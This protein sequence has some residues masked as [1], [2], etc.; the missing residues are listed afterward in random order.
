MLLFNRPLSQIDFDA[1]ERQLG[2]FT[3]KYSY[4]SIN[5][6]ALTMDARRIRAAAR[7]GE[8]KHLEYDATAKAAIDTASSWFGA[9]KARTDF[10]VNGNADGQTGYSKNDIVVAVIDTGIDT[11]HV[12]LDGGKV[13]GWQDFVAGKSNPYDDNGHGTHVASILA[14]EGQANPAYAGVAPGAALVG[15]KVLSSSG[16][17]SLSQV[18]A[19]VQ[20]AIDRRTS[21]NI[22]IIN[23]SLGLSGTSDGSD[24]LSQMV[25]SAVASGIVTVVA[26]GN[27]GPGTY[28]IGSPAAA[29]SVV[30]VGS[31]ADP[32]EAGF[33]LSFFSSRGPTADGRI[34][35][36]ITSPGQAIAA[37]RSG[38]TNS[39]ITLSG[40][41]MAAPFVA[42][43]AAL[44]LHAN[45]SLSPVAVKT[46]LTGTA[47]DWGPAG[48][49]IDYGVGRLDAHA[50]VKTAAGSNSGSPPAVPGHNFISGSLP[51]TGS[52]SFYSINVNNMV[53]P[54]AI[55]FIMP[56]WN[57]ADLDIYLYNPSGSLVS[58]S[59][60]SAR[61]ETIAY[62][63]LVTGVYKLEVRSFVGSGPYF[64]DISAGIS[65][66]DTTPPAAP[67]GLAVSVPVS[68]GQLLN[69]SW[70]ANTEPDLSGYNVYRSTA[71]AGPYQKVNSALV[72]SSSYADSGL[73]NGVAYFYIISA[74]D[75]SGNE[76]AKS[77][78]K[79]GM[80]VDNK[81][82]VISNLLATPSSVSGA[83]SW[84]TDELADST[85]EYGTTSAL[86]QVVSNV[87]LVSTHSINL[88]NLSPSTAYFY[89]VKSKDASDN[90]AT[91][92]VQTF[93]TQGLAGSIG[94]VV[95]AA[96]TGAP[97]SG[98]TVTDGIRSTITDNA[99]S[100]TINNIPAGT[101]TVT[102]SRSGYTA[103]SK[104]VT[105]I[106]G[107]TVSANFA[108][109]TAPSSTGSISGKVM[110][111]VT[112]TPIAGARVSTG[113]R[114]VF[115]DA[116]GNYAFTN[117]APGTY[118]VE[119]EAAGYRKLRRE[120]TL[121]AGAV[122]AVD[123]SLRRN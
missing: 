120:V 95:T 100:Y 45:S 60:G 76:S 54:I 16:S 85:V 98:V 10:G 24:A 88:T 5:G 13:I 90:L 20:W 93:T 4:P 68:N 117:L 29:A 74:V 71:A 2:D 15:I 23:L 6:V 50:A 59:L 22:R 102:A 75:S 63:P 106:A 67:T 91:S 80:P 99:G 53:Y 112:K 114:T 92:A 51:G 44:I 40:T 62:R 26:A 73:T 38:T 122:L 82:P 11:G 107:T 34:K 35:P 87:T 103:A 115:T 111:D 72:N 64:A 94:G 27:E 17:G 89:R 31:M 58:Y 96:A 37:A 113:S 32:G 19:G 47:V 42:G 28:S 101:Y 49:D 66:A 3:V 14:G 97:L 30:T 77:S 39:Y 70:N 12:D 36:D 57:A 104:S 52:S 108:L 84:N 43:V 123:F 7:F 55:S 83:V 81:A 121:N 9:A 116:G 69:L 8:V 33:F 79:S 61:Q 109:T 25:N 21:Y 78:E 110:D 41:S 118:R 86:G 46:I 48:A 56:G 1:L 119:A 105:V 65:T 18:L